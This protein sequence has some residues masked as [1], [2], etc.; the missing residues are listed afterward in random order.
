[1]LMESEVYWNILYNASLSQSNCIYFRTND[2]V[3]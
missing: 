2:N 3:R 1:M